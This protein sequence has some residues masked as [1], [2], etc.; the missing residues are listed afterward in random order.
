MRRPLRIVVAGSTARAPGQGGWAWAL[1]QYVLGF[2]QLGHR[3]F[4]IDPLERDRPGLHGVRLA[5]SHNAAWFRM[6]VSRFGL[7]DCS[8]LLVEREVETIGRARA[9]AI[10]A[11]RES[12]VLLNVSGV[13]KDDDILGA[14]ARRVYL[15]LDPGFTQ[16]WQAVEGVDM[17]LDAHTDFVTIGM[18]LSRS[19][20][21]DLDRQWIAT[22][23]PI[24]LEHW[25]PAGPAVERD[26]FTTVAN[27]RGY[28]SITADGTFFGQ[29]AHSFRQFLDLPTRT[30][31]RFAVALGI[32]PDERT[33]IDA[34]RTTGWELLDPASAAGTP[35]LFQRFVQGSLAEIAIAK[36]GYVVRPTG[37]F[38]DRS[39]CYLA[40]GR[41]VV[42]QDTG[43]ADVLPTGTGVLTFTTMDE[44]VESIRRVRRDYAEHARAARAIAEEC[45]DSGTV[46]AR[47]LRNLELAA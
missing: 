13:L 25:P 30:G 10:Q 37:W 3:V 5:R 34:L 21:P 36:R 15:D 43:L 16:L 28:G 44:A 2:R 35:D 7:D 18:T 46:L 32:H 27:W 22:R 41:P 19:G 6:L 33:D 20:L 4:W 29:K 38:S 47:L 17:R 9:V 24:V 26:A 39:I 8:S 23:Q 12:D 42:A 31:D 11:A 1:L 40:S 45:F 14:A